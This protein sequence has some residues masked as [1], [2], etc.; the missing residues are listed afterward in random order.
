MY[1]VLLLS[2]A[3]TEPYGSN[4]HWAE[5]YVDR[6]GDAKWRLKSIEEWV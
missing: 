3:E 2:V 6:G 5:I 1:T 4:L